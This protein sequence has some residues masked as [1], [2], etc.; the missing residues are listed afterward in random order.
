MPGGVCHSSART[1]HWLGEA[2]K[3]RKTIPSVSMIPGNIKHCVHIASLRAFLRTETLKGIWGWDVP[4]VST[5]GEQRSCKEEAVGGKPS[6][7]HARS[8]VPAEEGHRVQSWQAKV[9]P[10]LLP[11]VNLML[12]TNTQI[13]FVLSCHNMPTNS[14]SLI[15]LITGMGYPG[16]NLRSSHTSTP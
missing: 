7:F 10:C 1:W 4:T 9:A 11:G 6:R 3:L 15:S 5:A 16:V 12:P 8:P 2:L 14:I 13:C